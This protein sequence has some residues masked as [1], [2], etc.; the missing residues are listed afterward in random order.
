MEQ[1]G[2]E[3]EVFR[4]AAVAAPE[5]FQAKYLPESQR[6]IEAYSLQRRSYQLRMSAGLAAYAGALR[7][8]AVEA[9]SGK[10]V[11]AAARLSLAAA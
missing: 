8:G 10:G 2:G 9:L 11:G 6:Q 5:E 3:G 4:A 1:S 7:L